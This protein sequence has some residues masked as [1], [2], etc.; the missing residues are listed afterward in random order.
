MQADTSYKS[1]KGAKVLMA[2]RQFIVFGFAKLQW[3]KKKLHNQRYIS[4]EGLSSQQS[5]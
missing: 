3:L 1:Y 2:A 5:V 4:Q